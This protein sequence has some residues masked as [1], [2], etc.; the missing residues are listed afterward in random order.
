MR[1][2]LNLPLVIVA[3][4]LLTFAF[5][6]FDLFWI[7]PLSYAA[8]IY[9]WR[10]ATARQ[11]FLLGFSFGAASF[12]GGV[13]WVYISIH[14]FGQAHAVLAIVLT[15]ALVAILA[16]FVAA[17]GWLAARWFVTDGP[18]AWLGVF[19]ALWVLTEW[20]RGWILSGFGWLA[21]GYSQT[22]SW[23]MG[24]AALGGV[25]VMSWAVLLTA[26]ALV[27]LC[28]G[29][30]RARAV[31]GVLALSLW[32]GGY[33]ANGT[34]WTQPKG[35]L[36]TVALVQG[37]VPQDLKWQAAQ[38]V[39]TLDLYRDLTYQSEGSRLVVWPEAAVPAFY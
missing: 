8:L 3:G 11:A 7:A 37:A 2:N 4:G 24:Y 21:A 13:H 34:S 20:S 18:R 15:I 23:L 31:A 30:T 17:S 16:L 39:P 1:A 36:L 25:H 5:A 29:P 12:L 10:G 6:P 33:L 35:N 38:F 9:A 14:D 22:D 28:T 19:P 26:G 32:A 27:M